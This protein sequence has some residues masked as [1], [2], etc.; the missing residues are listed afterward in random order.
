MGHI[1]C[2]W[3]VV[4]PVSILIR[5]KA[6]KQCEDDKR[7]GKDCELPEYAQGENYRVTC[8]LWRPAAEKVF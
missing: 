3:G 5:K 7:R 4:C 2:I 1:L 6:D 8:L